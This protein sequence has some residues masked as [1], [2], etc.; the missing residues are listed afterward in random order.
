ME[1]FGWQVT[2]EVHHRCL[3]RAERKGVRVRWLAG[4]VGVVRLAFGADTRAG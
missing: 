2:T 1:V 4:P 3:D